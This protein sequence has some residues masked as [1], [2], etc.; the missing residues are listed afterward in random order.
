MSD[1]DMPIEDQ[2]YR[3]DLPVLR[4][5]ARQAAASGEVINAATFR[6]AQ[7]ADTD[8]AGVD[9]A[10]RWLEESRYIGVRRGP[11][12]ANGQAT[13]WGV[14]L[15]ERGRRTVGIWPSQQEPVDRLIEAFRQA[16]ANTSDDDDRSTLRRVAG[17]LAALPRDIVAE[18]L[19][20]AVT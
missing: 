17:Y 9:A 6:M 3:R 5:V 11:T 8:A 19:A 18:V 1:D 15:L 7:V 12:R 4:E 14:D 13:V 16:E 10:L 2:W 20:S